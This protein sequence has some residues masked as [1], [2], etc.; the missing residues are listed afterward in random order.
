MKS[1]KYTVHVG[2]FIRRAESSS[3]VFLRK[4]KFRK[5]WMANLYA[6]FINLKPTIC[7]FSPD[8]VEFF[9]AEVRDES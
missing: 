4:R 3:I 2:Y 7:K 5:K 1:K 8:S 6:L 9:F